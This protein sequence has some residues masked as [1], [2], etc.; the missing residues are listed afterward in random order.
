MQWGLVNS[1]FQKKGHFA[2]ISSLTVSESE[3]DVDSEVGESVTA[4]SR[5]RGGGVGG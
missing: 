5:G 1:I 2:I 3:D 4:L